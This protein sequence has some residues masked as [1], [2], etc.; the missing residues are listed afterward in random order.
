LTT[1]HCRLWEEPARGPPAASAT[2]DR[3]AVAQ[4]LIE[5]ELTFVPIDDFLA[6]W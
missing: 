4:A 2:A 3:D 1:S 6:D 5:T